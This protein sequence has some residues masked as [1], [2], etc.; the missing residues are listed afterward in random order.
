M[1]KEVHVID[2]SACNVIIKDVCEAETSV[3][4]RE[5]DKFWWGKAYPIRYILF[6]PT[7]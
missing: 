5:K 4:I 7:W 1:L 6:S 3:K 2:N